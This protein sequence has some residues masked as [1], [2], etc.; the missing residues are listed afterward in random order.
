MFCTDGNDSMAPS[1]VKVDGSVLKE[2]TEGVDT[3]MADVS[4]VDEDFDEVQA[5][6]EEQRLR[7]ERRQQAVAD[8]ADFPDEIETPHDVPARVCS[9]ITLAT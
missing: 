2:A 8:D 3:D 4:E 1:L 5:L 6:A 7:A 9:C